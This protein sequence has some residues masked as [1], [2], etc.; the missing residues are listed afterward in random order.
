M[1]EPKKPIN[2]FKILPSFRWPGKAA[3]LRHG[4]AEEPGN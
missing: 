3:D 4:V 2:F 1:P